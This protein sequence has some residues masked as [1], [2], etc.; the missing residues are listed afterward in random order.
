[1]AHAHVSFRAELLCDECV[2]VVLKTPLS[3]APAGGGG[4]VREALAFFHLTPGA[5]LE[6][7]TAVYRARAREAHPDSGGTEAA[8]KEV[9]RMYGILKDHYEKR[10]A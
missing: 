4:V 6:E 8:M 9:G 5:T 1:M 2:Q 7:V 3:R 10:A